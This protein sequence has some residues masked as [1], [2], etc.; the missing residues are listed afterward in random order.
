[1]PHLAQNLIDTSS[2]DMR[3]SPPFEGK[4]FDSS[5]PD[6]RSGGGDILFVNLLW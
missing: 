2:N 3:M 6:L 4:F 5:I 1:M